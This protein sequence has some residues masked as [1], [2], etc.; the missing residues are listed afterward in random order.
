MKQLES[1]MA[2]VL[3]LVLVLAFGVA[4]SKAAAGQSA[5][6]RDPVLGTWNLAVDKSIYDPGPAPRS[7]T[8]VYEA[9]PDGVKATINTIDAA[10]RSA[11]V[12]YI[13]DYDSMEYPLVGTAPGQGDALALVQLDPLLLEGTVTHAGRPIAFARRVISPDGQTMTITIRQAQSRGINVAVYE[14]EK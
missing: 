6:D 5:D 4:A 3:L 14:R 13:A 7:Q 8:R 2:G 11:K 1:R 9:H 12:L 10:G